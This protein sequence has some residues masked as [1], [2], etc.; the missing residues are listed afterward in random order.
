MFMKQIISICA[1]CLGIM[2]CA[3]SNKE[4]KRNND[5]ATTVIT[6]KFDSVEVNSKKVVDSINQARKDNINPPK[7]AYLSIASLD[8]TFR[9]GSYEYSFNE[10]PKSTFEQNF[11]YSNPTTKQYHS[12]CANIPTKKYPARDCADTVEALQLKKYED[13][14]Q[15]FPIV[16][17][18]VERFKSKGK[19]FAFG[20]RKQFRLADNMSY[21][22]ASNSHYFREVL[23]LNNLPY[24]VFFRQNW[25]GASYLIVSGQTGKDIVLN[26]IPQIS[27]NNQYIFTTPY[28]IGTYYNYA[29]IELWQANNTKLVQVLSLN[30]DYLGTPWRSYWLDEQTIMFELRQDKDNQE[31][32]VYRY[33]KVRFVEVTND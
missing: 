15:V 3:D 21:S 31:G 22:D 19:R 8:T 32:Q 16:N 18:A 27:P 5:T 20:S 24:F 25:E 12:L 14:I 33:A 6:H 30:F 26:G 2:A 29:G 7:K 28:D 23:E 13:F 17:Q 9:Q 11:K 1:L 4:N 10:I